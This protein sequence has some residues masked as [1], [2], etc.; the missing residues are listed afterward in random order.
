VIESTSLVVF[1]IDERRYA[2]HL[3]AVQRIVRAAALTPLAGAASDVLGLVNIHGRVMPVVNTRRRFGLTERPLVAD[4]VIIVA[5]SEAGSFALLAD[6]VVGV[7][8]AGA[9]DVTPVQGS[10]RGSGTVEGVLQLEDATVLIHSVDLLARGVVA[11]AT[12]QTGD[13][14]HAT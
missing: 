3:P 14:L 4:D 1:E 8:D 5:S 11:A 10:L 9:H 12:S 13:Q 6:R 7:I 2:L